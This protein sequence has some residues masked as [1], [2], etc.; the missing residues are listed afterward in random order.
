MIP[1]EIEAALELGPSARERWLAHF[2]DDRGAALTRKSHRR[3]M[4][5]LLDDPKVASD[6]KAEEDEPFPSPG[7][8][9]TLAECIVD[10]YDECEHEYDL[11]DRLRAA[12]VNLIRTECGRNRLHNPADVLGRL[13]IIADKC[14]FPELEDKLWGWIHADAYSDAEC[15]D[16]QR[17]VSLRTL[18]WSALISWGLKR[19]WLPLLAKDLDRD[20]TR[21]TCFRAIAK[22]DPLAALPHVPKIFRLDP[23]YAHVLVSGL[24]DMMGVDAAVHP[25]ARPAWQSCLSAIEYDYDPNVAYL[26]DSAGFRPPGTPLWRTLY[27]T[28]IE[29][30]RPDGQ[31]FTLGSRESGRSVRFALHSRST[32]EALQAARA[33]ADRTRKESATG[34]CYALIDYLRAKVA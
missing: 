26:S 9:K 2:L 17:S 22:L 16:G 25:D 4:A 28:G 24:I 12:V 30:G 27:D 21:A 20:D 14:G 19:E 34:C 1:A 13:L 23:P 5:R 15:W 31:T 10:A 6:P 8:K 3:W 7:P 18:M 29:L 33:L 32:S 11:R